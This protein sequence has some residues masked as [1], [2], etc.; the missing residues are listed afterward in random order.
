MLSKVSRTLLSIYAIRVSTIQE[1]RCILGNDLTLEGLVGRLTSF[2]LSNFDNYK[3]EN[4][5]STF[6]AKLLLKDSDEKK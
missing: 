6:K 3:A 1:L 5:E 2:E 4:L